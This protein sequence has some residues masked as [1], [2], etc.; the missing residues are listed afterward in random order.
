MK[1]RI[2]MF[3]FGIKAH[4]KFAWHHW[5]NV[6]ILVWSGHPFLRACRLSLDEISEGTKRKEAETEEKQKQLIKMW[7]EIGQR[8]EDNERMKGK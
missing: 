7:E 5:A 2:Y 8:K 6:A 1:T 4:I 3:Y